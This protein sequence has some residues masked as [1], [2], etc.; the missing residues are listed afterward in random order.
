MLIACDRKRCWKDGPGHQR[1]GLPIR[2]SS[3]GRRCSWFVDVAR[4]PMSPG[5]W[6]C[7]RGR[8]V[9]GFGRLRRRPRGAWKGRSR[10]APGPQ[11]AACGARRSRA[12]LPC[13]TRRTASG[14]AVE[15]RCSLAYRMSGSSC[16]VPVLSRAVEPRAGT[17]VDPTRAGVARSVGPGLV[18]LTAQGADANTVSLSR[19]AFLRRSTFPP[20]RDSRLHF[21]DRTTAHVQYR[22]APPGP[23]SDPRLRG[24]G[25]FGRNPSY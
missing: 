1:R 5:R 22:A 15:A 14:R 11:E 8:S 9:V 3:D 17:S 21:A 20:A 7:R 23:R 13:S 2:S 18:K 25:R 6:R 4:S 19:G 10:G 16:D 12:P 24:A